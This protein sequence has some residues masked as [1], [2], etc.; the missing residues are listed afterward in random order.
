M[1]FSFIPAS[2][3][4]AD[5]KPGPIPTRVRAL[6]ERIASEITFPRLAGYRWE[7]PDEHLAGRLHRRV[8]PRARLPYGPDP[9]RCRRRRRGDRGASP[10]PLRGHA[11]AGGGVPLAAAS[12]TATTA[13]FDEQ[14]QQVADRPWLVPRLVEIAKAWID[15]VRHR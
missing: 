1:P 14:G 5:P 6:P 12:T 7:V 4:G 13:Q 2:G 15:R 11:R 9:H 10:R 3:A 8:A